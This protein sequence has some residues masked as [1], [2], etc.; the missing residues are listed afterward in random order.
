[1]NADIEHDATG[2]IVHSHINIHSREYRGRM[3]WVAEDSVGIV[4][5]APTKEDLIRLL[6]EMGAMH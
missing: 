4:A 2:W 5:I 3:T 1:M 6:H